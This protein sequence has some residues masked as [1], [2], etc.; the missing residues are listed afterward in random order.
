MPLGFAGDQIG[1]S[2]I[3]AQFFDRSERTIAFKRGIDAFNHPDFYAQLGKKSQHLVTM[4]LGYWRSD[5][6]CVDPQSQW[7][8][9][10]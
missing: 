4:A 9:L 7:Q 2:R 3:A 5:L 8:P 1:A 6:I 10:I